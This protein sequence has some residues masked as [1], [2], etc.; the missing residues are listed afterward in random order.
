MVVLGELSQIEFLFSFFFF[1][2]FFFSFF[3]SFQGKIQDA[4]TGAFAEV[5]KKILE[6]DE[7]RVIP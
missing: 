4:I 5:D 3:L 7:K 2:L 6:S 1:F